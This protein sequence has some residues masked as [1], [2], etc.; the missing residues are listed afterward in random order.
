[1]ALKRIEG[2]TKEE[3]DLIHHS[4]RGCQYTSSEYVQLLSANGIRVSMTENGDPKE[5]ALAERMNGT[6]KNKLSKGRKFCSVA[7]VRAAVKDAVTFYNNECPH[8]PKTTNALKSYFGH[9]KEN[10][11]LHRG[12]SKKHYRNYVKWYIYFRERDNKAKRNKP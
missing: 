11:S 10:I 6:V 1:M 2:V 12:L 8:I 7:E 9:L 3:I 4:D 5:N